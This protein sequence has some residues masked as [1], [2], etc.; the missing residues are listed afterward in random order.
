MNIDSLSLENRIVAVV[1]D[2]AALVRNITFDVEEKNGAINI[3]T[4]RDLAVQHYLIAELPKLLPGCGFFCEEEGLQDTESEYIFVIDPI[5]GTANYARGIPESAIS[6]ALFHDGRPIVGV[7]CNIL[8]G[9]LFSATA[10]HGARRNGCAIRTAAARSFAEGILC[11]A[12]SLYKKEFARV[13][14]D[15]IYE[16]Y[17]QCNDVRRFGG[18]ALELCYLACGRCDLYFEIRVFPWD[19]A[20][21]ALILTEAGGKVTTLDGGPI[22]LGAPMALIGANN[23]ENHA[24]LLSIVHRHLKTLPYKD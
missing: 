11:T 20:A 8:T 24:C 19:C 1:R 23:E 3:V 12:M 14:D 4:T 10:G 17:L 22:A 6:V 5:D 18:C 16:T 7:V 2:A 13:C 21:G 9:E 15:I